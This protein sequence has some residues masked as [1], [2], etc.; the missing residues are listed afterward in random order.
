MIFLFH[1]NWG[2]GNHIFGGTLGQ[3]FITF[4]KYF[5]STLLCLHPFFKG[6][7]GEP[8]LSSDWSPYTN[9]IR[10]KRQSH[11][12]RS[13]HHHGISLPIDQIWASPSSIL[14]RTQRIK[15]YSKHKPQTNHHWHLHII[16]TTYTIRERKEAKYLAKDTIMMPIHNNAKMKA[17][18][19]V[20][21]FLSPDSLGFVPSTSRVAVV[22]RVNTPS[23]PYF[24][25]NNGRSTNFMPVHKEE[26]KMNVE[27]HSTADASSDGEKKGFLG[28][29][30]I[31]D[32][33]LPF[34]S[35]TKW[36]F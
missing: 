23:N 17:S 9:P 7:F 2:A 30:G 26:E 33:K 13:F 31:Y 20:L 4:V 24:M 16:Y 5:Y 32:G 3:N 19:A 12:W 28:K 6:H 36:L 1:I 11:H 10:H 34:H 14:F 21:L 18:L 27:R 35:S 25:P 8:K 29:V 15:T 22:P